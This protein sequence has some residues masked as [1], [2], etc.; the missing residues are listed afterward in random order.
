[1]AT[2]I[3]SLIISLKP[4][5]ADFIKGSKDVQTAYEKTKNEAVKSSK[6]VEESHKKIEQGINKV[7]NGV[8]GLFAV[9]MAGRGWKEFISDVNA[10]N[11]SLGRFSTQMGISPK[12]VGEFEQAIERVGGKA[13]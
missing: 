10:A 5:P 8:L 6:A 11:L 4:D 2:L 12:W 3:D 9:L 1:M 13:E 7:T